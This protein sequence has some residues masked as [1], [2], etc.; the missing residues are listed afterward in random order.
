MKRH[1]KFI[2]DP[3]SCGKWLPFAKRK[4][5]SLTRLYRG[6]RSWTWERV[7]NGAQIS[8]ER[9]GSVEHIRITAGVT[10]Y[11]FATALTAGDESF[12]WVLNFDDDGSEKPVLDIH[13]KEI[14]FS[15]VGLYSDP[16]NPGEFLL[17]AK[18]GR[19]QKIEFESDTADKQ[20]DA[21][22]YARQWKKLLELGTERIVPRL[23]WFKIPMPDANGETTIQANEKAAL[24][25]AKGF[26]TCNRIISTGSMRA[27]HIDLSNRL[28]FYPLFERALLFDTSFPILHK[29]G[30]SQKII[31]LPMQ[32]AKPPPKID[33]YIED[34]T[35][36]ADIDPL[37]SYCGSAAQL[38][39]Y[40]LGGSIAGEDYKFALWDA[41]RSEETQLDMTGI[42]PAW[43]TADPDK[44]AYTKWYWRGDGKRC[45]SMQ[46]T[47]T[48]KDP[49]YPN[50]IVPLDPALIIPPS[51]ANAL[52]Y[53]FT[54]LEWSV[55]PNDN[56]APTV[57]A[58]HTLNV[59][60]FDVRP[61]GI[62]YDLFDG[63]IRRTV[64]LEPWLGA[65]FLSAYPG[66]AA[67]SIRAL[68]IYAHFCTVDD[69]GNISDP[70]FSIPMFHQPWLYA[71][72]F[73][74]PPEFLREYNAEP[75]NIFVLH[76]N[77][78]TQDEYGLWVHLYV[79]N[80][81][82]ELPG[83]VSSPPFKT[84]F[85]YD[86]MQSGFNALDLRA[87]AAALRTLVIDRA[88]PRFDKVL[89]MGKRWR[90][91]D[92][93]EYREKVWVNGDG[94]YATPPFDPMDALLTPEN[95]AAPPA[96]YVK[97]ASGHALWVPDLV[98][99]VLHRV[100]KFIQPN[101]ISTDTF[102]DNPFND[103]MLH[104]QDIFNG[105]RISP[106][107]H[108]AVHVQPQTAFTADGDTHASRIRANKLSIDH[109]EWFHGL[110]EDDNPIVTTST[111]YDLYNAA[112][113]TT[114]SFE[115]YRPFSISSNGIW[116]V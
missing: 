6:R 94:T 37:T 104:P 54:E 36:Q 98:N 9:N 11:E 2:G 77:Y 38:D 110:D 29:V 57:I 24:W 107:K 12:Y 21:F 62:D 103:L 88:S 85:G 87:Q 25:R 27:R 82:G 68:L 114:F 53:G 22:L 65:P 18:N 41:E 34:G 93:E 67:E 75:V 69:D 43:V 66:P 58:T 33:S 74:T 16:E 28:Q 5:D 20:K 40:I 50:L 39:G 30:G 48:P 26:Q 23:D 60:G 108:F 46:Y 35:L 49:N 44:S 47:F 86:R 97:F 10:G 78:W 42:R 51:P 111:H 80:T 105:F 83:S 32:H 13:H 56:A 115:G 17:K 84:L 59:N 72:Y 112:R 92:E 96:G 8:L 52:E 64:V 102:D 101:Y 106:K 15:L 61:L 113:E 100:Y 89:Y 19:G 14:K 1:I 3:G 63:R 76:H 95:L 79:M 45:I 70:E 7:I 31:E 109:V 81:L 99:N 71:K 91:W 73:A 55:T 4:L 116:V 90:I